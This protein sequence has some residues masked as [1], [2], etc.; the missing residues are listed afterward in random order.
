MTQVT[1][2]DALAAA[3]RNAQAAE[4]EFRRDASARIATLETERAFSYRRLNWMKAV[5]GAIADAEDETAALARIRA[6][7]TDRLGWETQDE[8]RA[9]VQVRFDAVARA[10][11]AAM[12]PVD[13]AVP[14]VAA[15][16]AAFEAW[17][18]E[19]RGRPF[20]VLF[21]QSVVELPLVEC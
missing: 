3:A 19:S 13:G 12:T 4:A 11:F 15:E 8:S 14:D 9:E 20:W 18:L 17:Y 1:Y 5:A 7:L 2:L 10:M 21:E 6:A 16:L